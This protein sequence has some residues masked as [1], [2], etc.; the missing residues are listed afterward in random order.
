MSAP[1]A[2]EHILIDKRR[3]QTLDLEFEDTSDMFYVRWLRAREGYVT[4]AKDLLR[5]HA[6]YIEETDFFELRTGEPPEDFSK[7]IP[8]EIIGFDV[9]NCPSFGRL[10]PLDNFKK[11]MMAPGGKHIENLEA[12]NCETLLSWSFL[13]SNHDIGF[14]LSCENEVL[15]KYARVEAKLRPQ[16]GSDNCQH[17]GTYRI[18]FDNSF[19]RMRAKEVNFKVSLG[20]F[21]STVTLLTKTILLH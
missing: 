7:K 5:K 14:S 21:F 17:P 19:R 4:K 9:D 15:V 18:I 20:C 8:V 16:E 10:A 12:N 1:N 11:V 2:E 6:Q 3:S 13:T